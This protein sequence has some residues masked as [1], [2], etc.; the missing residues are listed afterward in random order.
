LLL[1]VCSCVLKER[2][3]DLEAPP[4]VVV[5][6]HGSLSLARILPSFISEGACFFEF[7]FLL[8]TVVLRKPVNSNSILFFLSASPAV[9]AL[10]SLSFGWCSLSLF[11]CSLRLHLNQ[12]LPY[13]RCFRERVSLPFPRTLTE[14]L[15]QS[16][17][18][19]NK[20]LFVRLVFSFRF[21]FFHIWYF[22]LFYRHPDNLF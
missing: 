22:P 18:K 7:F 8:L 12:V 21:L 19:A 9:R 11:A 4:F 17:R 10:S 20:C 3:H 13:K 16:N 14:T 1:F 2:L 15:V 6:T 5:K